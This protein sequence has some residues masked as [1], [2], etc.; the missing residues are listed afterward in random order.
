ML[1]TMLI[2][3]WIPNTSAAAKHCAAKPY[4]K[5]CKGRDESP[6]TLSSEDTSPICSVSTNPLPD[7]DKATPL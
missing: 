1:E 4:T 2:E 5:P 6:L 7:R 3:V